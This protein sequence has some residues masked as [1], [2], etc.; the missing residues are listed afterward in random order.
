[1]FKQTFLK[2]AIIGVASLF[3]TNAM[4]DTTVYIDS[5]TQTY[6]PGSWGATSNGHEADGAADGVSSS[7]VNSGWISWQTD[8]PYT[9]FDISFVLTEL[10]PNSTIYVY[11]GNTDAAN[12]WFTDLRAEVVSSFS[13]GTNN[14]SSAAMSAHCA[15]IGGCNLFLLYN[16][17]G[18]T[19]SIDTADLTSSFVASAPEPTSWALMLLGFVAVAGRLKYM[20]KQGQ[21]MKP[22]ARAPTG[23]H[24]A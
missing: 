3:A 20:R 22:R 13:V 6:S 1:M 11:A 2:M 23:L 14:Y 8:S 18:G 16:A 24:A 5:T 7:S 4:A 9:V 12:G 17:S 15:S 10:G 19:M 21:I